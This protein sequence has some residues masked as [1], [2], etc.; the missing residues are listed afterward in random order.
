MTAA[1]EMMVNIMPSFPEARA[2]CRFIPKPSPT[3]QPCSKYFW[4]FLA[5]LGNAGPPKM[6]AYTIPAISAIQ[7]ATLGQQAAR[8][9]TTKAIFAIFSFIVSS[10]SVG[11]FLVRRIKARVFFSPFPA[12]MV[13]R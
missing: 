4:V 11:S 6:K 1:T 2:A 8:I 3:T 10:Y 9:K 13:K 12:S 7:E 5:N